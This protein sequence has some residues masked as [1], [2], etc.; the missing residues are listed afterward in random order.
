MLD[1]TVRVV[2]NSSEYSE[3]LRGL[4]RH[5]TDLNT[6]DQLP[7]L[8]F[9][10]FVAPPT[11][12][13]RSASSH[14]IQYSTDEEIEYIDDYWQLFRSLEWELHDYLSRHVRDFHLL[15]S[16]A[17]ARG[18]KGILFPGRSGS[19]KSSM[20]LSLVCKGYNYLSDELAVI[21]PSTDELHAFP[22]QVNVVDR[23]IFPDL[24][25]RKNLWFKPDRKKPKVW[26]VHTDDIPSGPISS[27]VPVRYII[28]PSYGPKKA[29]RLIPIS[30][31]DALQKLIHNSVNF[32]ILSH[33]G[34]A[35]LAQLVDGARC[36]RLEFNDLNESTALVDRLLDEGDL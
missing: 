23:S 34:L 3:H 22:E 33:N 8:T 6:Y 10:V 36:F 15:H 26:Y 35:Q 30:R 31:G 21:N 17:V 29:S 28:F 24:H 18:G 12:K 9:S 2:S 16:G 13:G 19:G 25:H 27:P 32:E 14:Y 11:K 20:T 5:F 7:D 1:K 4:W